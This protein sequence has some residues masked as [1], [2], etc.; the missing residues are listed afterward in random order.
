MSLHASDPVFSGMGAFETLLG[1]RGKVFAWDAHAARLSRSLHLLGIPIPDLSKIPKVISEILKSSSSESRIRVTITGNSE[2]ITN[3]IVSACDYSRPLTEVTLATS[4][5]SVNERSPLRHAKTL[6]YAEN[7]LL[8]KEAI[9]KKVD[10]VLVLNSSGVLAEAS[11]S[12]VIICHEG[13]LKTPPLESGCLPGVTRGLLME[14][15]TSIR[16]EVISREALA[17]ADEVWLCNSLRRL[18]FATELDGR[19]LHKPTCRFKEL[20][21]ALESLISRGL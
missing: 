13:I 3:V 20:S 18:Q 21:E 17:G 4:S 14:I 7:F 9:A 11:M 16:E 6:S 8:Q 12:N 19:R 5:Q 10:D 15:E 1:V 2:K